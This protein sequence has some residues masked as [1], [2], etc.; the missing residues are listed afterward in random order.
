MLRQARI[1]FAITV[2]LVGGA[3]LSPPEMLAH[4]PWEPFLNAVTGEPTI[5]AP[6]DRVRRTVALE[7]VVGPRTAGAGKI[8]AP[9]KGVV[10]PGLPNLLFVVDQVGK[11]WTVNLTTGVTTQFLD[12]SNLLVDLGVIFGEGCQPPVARG[13]TPSFDERG[14]LGLAFHPDFQT[15]GKFYTYTSEPVGPEPTFPSTCAPNCDHQN[16]VSEWTV[17]PGN[18]FGGVVGARRELMRVDWPQFNHDGGDLAF[19]PDRLLYISMGDGGGADDRDGQNF[20]VPY[21][22]GTEAPIIGHGQGNAQNLTNPLGKILRIA[23]TYAPSDA[24]G[25]A[26]RSKNKEYWIPAGNPLVKNATDTTVVEIF[27]FGFRNP[28]RM[29]FDSQTGKLYVGDVGQNDIEEVDVVIRGGN[30]G[31]NIKEGTLI[32]CHNFNAEGF[33]TPNPAQFSGRGCPALLPPNLI[34]PI[35]QYD[36]H[37]E[38]HSVIGGFVYR[39]SR[40]PELAGRYLFGD[41]SRLFKFPSGPHDYGRLFHVQPLAEGLAPI[42]EFQI[43]D[44]NQLTIALLGWGQDAAG[45]L[46]V[47]GNVF[48]LPF[49]ETV[50][51][52]VV[53]RGIVMRIA[54]HTEPTDND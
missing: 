37:H 30:Y 43:A 2:M 8:T 29:S 18:P 16:V 41:F 17:A 51:E 19:G 34:D 7:T 38:G 22:C 33:A 40:I 3:V 45:E 53:P 54:P 49:A 47:M 35:A 10:A 20:I 25:P 52:E 24:T 48:G 27:A 1:L 11:V 44:G 15:N 28:F 50:E 5:F 31:W 13:S 9:I 6:I 42:R 14:L 26:N 23:P 39:G 32:F 4:P 46:Y 36:T 21:T 12:V